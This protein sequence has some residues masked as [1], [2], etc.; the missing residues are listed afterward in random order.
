MSVSFGE[1]PHSQKKNSFAEVAV[2]RRSRSLG[3]PFDYRIPDEFYKVINVGSF[4]RVP[5]GKTETL[6]V[7]TLLKEKSQID[8]VR[9]I[10]EVIENGPKLPAHAIQLSSWISNHFITGFSQCL[11]LY[12]PPGFDPRLV[13]V[14]HLKD[15][16][17]T[18][19]PLI[20]FLI[21][22]GGSSPYP[23]IFSYFGKS[24]AMMVNKAKEKNSI[25]IH[26]KIPRPNVVEKVGFDIAIADVAII[27]EIIN[28]TRSLRLKAALEII[29]DVGRISYEELREKVG[30]TLKQ[31]EESARRQAIF[32]EKRRRL[33]TRSQL[34]E[35]SKNTL[36]YL[37]E[38]QELA[39]EKILRSIESHESRK[40]LLRGVT[41]SGK[42][43]VYL[44]AAEAAVRKGR[45]VIYLVPEIS[46]TSQTVARVERVFGKKVA[47]FHSGMKATE[48]LDEWLSLSEGIKKI[49]VGPRSAL[50]VPIE[51]IGLIVID[52][53]HEPAY[54]QETDPRYDTRIVAEKLSEITKATVIFGSAT[55]S[56]ER[57]YRAEIGEIELIELPKRISGN[58]PII[59][60]V[61]LKKEKKAISNKLEEALLDAL[62]E[63]NKG[64][65]FLN[66]RG[67]AVT[68]TCKDCGSFA[69]CPD[70][71]VAYRYH[72][73][74]DKLICHYCSKTKEPIKKCLEC[75]SDNIRL[76]GTGTQRLEEELKK[77]K[78]LMQAEIVR[79][80]SDV[81]RKGRIRQELIRFID[82]DASVMV[83]TQMIAKGLDFPDV[84]FVGVVNAD[85]SLHLPD[86]RAEERTFQ[87][88]AQVIGRTGRGKK[89]SKVI[90][91]TWNPEREV[92]RLAVEENYQSFY[93]KELIIRKALSY[94][95]FVELTRVV[96]VSKDEKSAASIA[97]E[98]C[99]KL[100][101]VIGDGETLIGP[102]P[103]PIQKIRG[104]H[105][106]HLILKSTK[107]LSKQ[108]R[109]MLRLLTSKRIKSTKI[110][111]D[112]EPSTL[113]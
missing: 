83:G 34:A 53:E 44:K 93:E 89:P 64:I 56:V 84:T 27:E 47:L 62:R 63:K 2:F 96:V 30:V 6:G 65:L 58:E 68:L 24:A 79:M 77:L 102:S 55:P 109:E 73:D 21:S 22:K 37:N 49:V 42:T 91:Q 43:E 31:L 101:D 39:V 85:V 12:L 28:T 74:V 8:K 1:N 35:G 41:G 20:S 54:K 78:E 106:F 110:L 36:D 86:F 111:V 81:S 98:V 48:R 29:L 70:C 26:W 7:V 15:S 59:E 105:R 13:K 52:E 14:I 25:S 19:N 4:V 108:T 16:S 38:E 72:S 10:L 23:L 18:E 90:V 80:D 11:E 66:R 103:A 61:D 87:L 40:F 9:P 50:F 45:G 107:P 51:K 92:I 3:E 71:A 46:L 100:K 113:M 95:P 17:D 69:Q 60:I 88:L 94:P 32:I 33:R 5:F 99:S 82:A 104:E 97:E 76:Q 75:E 67:Y 57:M 112:V